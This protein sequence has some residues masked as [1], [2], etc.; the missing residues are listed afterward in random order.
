MQKPVTDPNKAN[1]EM[2]ARKPY[3][4]PVLTVYGT[5]GALTRSAGNSGQSDGMGGAN[6]TSTSP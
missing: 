4:A 6:M 3:H 1:A 2:Q 5:L